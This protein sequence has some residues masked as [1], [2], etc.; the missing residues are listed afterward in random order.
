PEVLEQIEERRLGPVDVLEDE[1]KRSV[2]RGD[3]EEPAKGPRDLAIH[4]CAAAR[5]IRSQSDREGKPVSDTLVLADGGD[6]L[7]DLGGRHL[8]GD[9][10]D[11]AEDLC[12][13]PVRDPLA[14][15]E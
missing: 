4:S 5:R 3:L 7:E 9:L 1:E 11:L 10:G 13:R 12:Y 15:G 8:R 6:A 2:D 14:V